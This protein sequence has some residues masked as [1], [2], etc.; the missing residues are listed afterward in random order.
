MKASGDESQRLMECEVGILS[1]FLLARPPRGNA[2]E[3]Q[4]MEE[5]VGVCQEREES[6]TGRSMGHLL[7]VGAKTVER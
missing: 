4:V 3:Q 2:H 1:G 5:S 7:G 6:T